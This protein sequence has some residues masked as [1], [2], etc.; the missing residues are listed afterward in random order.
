[1]CGR[2]TF[3]EFEGT[4]ERFRIEPPNLRPNYNVAPSQDV[5][6]I[7]NNGANQLAYSI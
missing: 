4:E 6:V 1:M 3:S 7:I 2:F 5:P